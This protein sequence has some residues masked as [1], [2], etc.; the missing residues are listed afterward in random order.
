MKKTETLK[1]LTV[2]IVIF[3]LS[4]LFFVIFNYSNINSPMVDDNVFQWEPI[5]EKCFADIFDGR[6]IPYYN[7]YEYRG[8]D[9]FSTG[10]YGQLNPFM[11]IAY[12]ISRFI[13]SFDIKVLVVYIIMM[14]SLG[15]V[16]MYKMLSEMKISPSVKAIMQLS[17][18]TSFF[19]FLYEFYYFSFNNFFF[20]PFF[21]LM[22]YKTHDT[23]YE[24]FVP[25]VLLAASMLLGH[26]QYSSYYVIL[27]CV[28]QAVFAVQKKSIR[29]LL[30]MFTG[31][32]AF[33][34][35]NSSY[36]ISM[37]GSSTNRE[38]SGLLRIEFFSESIKQSAILKLI[39]IVITPDQVS[40]RYN[41]QKNV[42]LGILPLLCYSILISKRIPEFADKLYERFC[43]YRFNKKDDKNEESL[44]KT[45]LT[46]Y[47]VSII[48]FG[49]FIFFFGDKDLFTIISIVCYVVLAVL[50][51]R[52]LLKH[53]KYSS[54]NESKKLRSLFFTALTLTAII[55][56]F[57]FNIAMAALVAGYCWLFLGKKRSKL[58]FTD[59]EKFI[60]TLCFAALFFMVLGAGEEQWLANI[61]YHV[62]IFN[63]FRFLYKCAFL[64][65]PLMTIIGA[66]L[67]NKY[68]V[69]EGLM[70]KA[71]KPALILIALN[72]CLSVTS[73]LY[74]INSGEHKYINNDYY[75]YFDTD[76]DKAAIEKRMDELG[77]D[78]N[79]RFLTLANDHD[80]TAESAST[81]CS[82]TLAKNY[83]TTFSAF[84]LAGYD[85][86][87]S[88]TSYEQSDHILENISSEYNL[89]GIAST[90]ILNRLNNTDPEFSSVMHDQFVRNGVRYIIYPKAMEEYYT[91]MVSFAERFDDISVVRNE[92]WVKDCMIMELEGT[93]PVCRDEQNEELN[94]TTHMDEIS[95]EIAFEKPETVRLSLVYNDNILVEAVDESGSTEIITAEADEY[96]YIRVVVPDGRH[97]VKVTYQSGIKDIAVVLACVS[98]ILAVIS[99][100][101]VSFMKKKKDVPAKA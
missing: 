88:W 92:P 19:F 21:I 75:G 73:I 61:L 7:F 43:N 95:F 29:P 58:N 57:P 30:I 76:G 48:F 12:L 84:T 36:M 39:N 85:S 78:K 2:E 4:I 23:K 16:M 87:F 94:L 98:L 80:L 44:K 59:D 63:R 53:S 37:M 93:Y 32:M 41:Y 100:V 101:I 11:Y 81:M 46:I 6:G 64:Y 20:V 33:G 13:F 26:I 10:Y 69:S 70:K 62:P 9:I 3:A 96:G 24:W 71:V 38:K 83:S 68:K 55:A 18:A 45:I 28:I 22:L 56:A 40:D 72:S 67:L 54:D 1:K 35:L 86:T 60:H 34:L 17:Y 97:T 25:P 42:C 82:Y 27:F 77:I 15:N 79:Y 31:I 14:Y 5:I 66:F 65:I 91:S 51:L 52:Y 8:L 47:D 49:I 50:A 90:K 89:S 99:V 74:T